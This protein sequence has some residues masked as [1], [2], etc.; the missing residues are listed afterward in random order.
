M[1]QNRR[2]TLDAK[3]LCENDLYWLTGHRCPTDHRPCQ[4]SVAAR[5]EKR[6][7]AVEAIGFERILKKWRFRPIP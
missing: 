7:Q 3:T 1:R 4:H 5:S 2:R 6:L